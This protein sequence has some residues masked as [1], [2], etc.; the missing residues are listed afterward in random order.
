[1]FLTIDMAIELRRAAV[2]VA[3]AGG[4]AGLCVDPITTGMSAKPRPFRAT[5]V[6]ATLAVA[7][8]I[9][10]PPAAPRAAQAA[11]IEWQTPIDIARGDG[12]RGPWRQNDS[13]FRFVDDPT[14]AWG[15]GGE[16]AVAWVDQARKAVLLQRLPASGASPAAAPAEIFGDRAAFSWLP[17]LAWAPDDADRLHLLWQEIIF[18]GGS[19]GGEVMSATSRDGGRSV[20]SALNL[21]QSRAGDGKG[22]S[23]P[24]SLGERQPGHRRGSG[25]PGDRNVDGVRRPALDRLVR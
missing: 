5:R 4:Q 10:S 11:A 3:R 13:D 22:R 2:A 20:G 14:V 9:L 15:P 7:L 21:S 8:A 17:R 24:R 16:L 12:Q 19:H 6:C 25:R 1:V 18:S 23:S